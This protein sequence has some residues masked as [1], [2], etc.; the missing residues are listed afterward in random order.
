MLMI[1][2]SRS[3]Q[4]AKVRRRGKISS[5]RVSFNMSI[6]F[7]LESKVDIRVLEKQLSA[8]YCGCIRFDRSRI[9][10]ISRLLQRKRGDMSDG[11]GLW[12]KQRLVH[13]DG[14]DERVGCGTNRHLKILQV[15]LILGLLI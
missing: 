6:W 14:R 2:W 5:S 12:P 10:M 1:E 9:A 15:E 7:K 8:G 13:N 4:E 3:D 11:V